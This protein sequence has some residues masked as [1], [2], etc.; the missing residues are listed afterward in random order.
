MRKSNI[1]LLIVFAGI[2][3]LVGFTR[4]AL[5]EK[6][7]KDDVKTITRLKRKIEI[8]EQDQQQASLPSFSHIVLLQVQQN[9]EAIRIKDSVVL[10]KAGK[11]EAFLKFRRQT[12]T[13]NDVNIAEQFKVIN[14]TL[15][16]Q[17][18]GIEYMEI[19]STGL[20]SFGAEGSNWVYPVYIDSLK[21][22]MLTVIVNPGTKVELRDCHIKRFKASAFNTGSITC[23]SSS[24][25]DTLD[26]AL[27]IYGEVVLEDF[28]GVPG[29]IF[30][31]PTAK[32]TLT[33]KS[34]KAFSGVQ[35]NKQGPYTVHDAGK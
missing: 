1:V 11:Q 28:E 15:Y 5:I 8:R 9:M 12:F 35:W 14:D 6:F 10:N 7:E 30:L 33:G 31:Y 20:R 32:L 4:I 26:L 21:K 18:S 13:D 24:K 25:I 22:D 29:S 23:L 34:I 2:F 16:I 3:G 27:D 17:S 19:Y